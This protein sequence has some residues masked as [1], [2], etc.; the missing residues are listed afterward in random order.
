MNDLKAP[1]NLDL[2]SSNSPVRVIITK[3]ALQEGW[4]CPFAYVLCSLATSSNLSAMTQLVGRILRQPY[5]TKTGIEPL[6]QCYVFCHHAKTN[7]VIAKIKDGLEQ[8]GMADLADEVRNNSDDNGGGG[9]GRLVSRRKG[10]EDI[11]IFMPVINWV[12]GAT[13]RPLDYEQ[14]VLLAIEWKAI[15]LAPLAKLIPKNVQQ[16][17][18]Q[19]TQI[20]VGDGTVGD[21]FPSMLSQ[22]V[23]EF[24]EFDPIY[25]T[26]IIADI[27]PNPWI[28]RELVQHLLDLLHADGFDDKKLGELSSLILQELRKYLTAER[29]LLAEQHF[30]Q[31]VY[32]SRVQ[33]RLRTD[34]HNWHIPKTMET[35]RAENSPKLLRKSGDPVE[36]S[37]FAPVYQ[38]DFNNDEA[39]VACYLDE[40]KALVW[41]HRNVAKSGQYFVQ[42]WRKNKVYPDFIFAVARTDSSQKF[43]VIETKGD[44]LEGNLDT[45]YKRKLLD[46]VNER[47]AFENVKKAGE[48]ELVLDD[49]TTVSCELILMSEWAT[50]LPTHIS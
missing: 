49:K 1:E 27:V 32:D 12:D 38:L 41:W 26:R 29:D 3:Q 34:S 22:S 24:S 20:T 9:K 25:A 6:D 13:V 10:F 15:D 35:N 2:L 21:F 36:K 23:D 14:D 44:Q 17:A 31:Q 28:A 50:K 46:V 48:L 33:F 7:E 37:L 30:M 4:D 19:M 47:Y 8:D 11:E 16:G 5:A 43:V 42:G 45:N 18:S 39:D 40:E